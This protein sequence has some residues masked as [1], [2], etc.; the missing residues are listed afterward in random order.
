MLINRMPEMRHRS[1]YEQR[2]NQGESEGRSEP[3]G[4]L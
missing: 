3:T 4:K 1:R 2:G